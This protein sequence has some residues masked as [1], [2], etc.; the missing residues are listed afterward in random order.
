M[1]EK[2]LS[3][4]PDP[5]LD[6]MAIGFKM[7]KE[8]ISATYRIAVRDAA[9]RRNESLKSAEQEYR[10]ELHGLQ[11]GRQKLI[12]LITTHLDQLEEIYRIMEAMRNRVQQRER[13]DEEIQW[14]S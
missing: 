3:L 6:N 5:A 1:P 8:Q 4:F 13:I 12:S 7:R 2:Q 14:S 11:Q 9:R 10:I